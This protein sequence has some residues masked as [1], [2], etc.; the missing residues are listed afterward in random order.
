MTSQDNAWLDYDYTYH[1]GPND[2][3]ERPEIITVLGKPASQVI[4]E[5]KNY[6]LHEGQI[7]QPVVVTAEKVE[8]G[9]LVEVARVEIPVSRICNEKDT[10]NVLRVNLETDECTTLI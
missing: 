3:E 2:Y 6:A 5:V 7:T 4:L 9:Q 1:T 8:N 10:V